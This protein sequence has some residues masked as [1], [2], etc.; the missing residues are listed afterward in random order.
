MPEYRYYCLTKEGK[1]SRG[2]HIEVDD[3]ATAIRAAYNDCGSDPGHSGRIEVWQ[4]ARCLYT[5]ADTALE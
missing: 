3:L 1:I 4:N 5:T 2:T